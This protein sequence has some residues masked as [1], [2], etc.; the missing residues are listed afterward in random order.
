MMS[1]V[2]D[3]NRKQ[4]VYLF[5]RGIMQYDIILLFSPPVLDN[6]INNAFTT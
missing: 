2:S 5:I 4:Q 1:P 6:K 3:V